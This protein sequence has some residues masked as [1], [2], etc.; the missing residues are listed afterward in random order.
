MAKGESIAPTAKSN[1]SAANGCVANLA[2]EAKLW[3]AADEFRI[4]IDAADCK[5]FVLGLIFL[6]YISDNTIDE[7]QAKPVAGNGDYAGAKPED[8]DECEAE[9]VFWVPK[10]GPW[11]HLQASAKQPAVGKVVNVAMVAIERDNPRLKGVLCQEYPR[12]SLD[13]HRPGE[14][15]D[16]IDTIGLGDRENRARHILDRVYECFLTQS[17][18]AEGLRAT[19]LPRLLSGEFPVSPLHHQPRGAT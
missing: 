8:K 17:A 15:I 2:F 1:G 11:A 16:L 19:L 12:P 14:P 18:S 6:R 5:H 13:R 9:K 4:S 10:E 7:H 3:P